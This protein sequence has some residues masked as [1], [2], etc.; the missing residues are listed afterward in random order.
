MTRVR[1]KC[2][3]TLRRLD[4]IEV[5]EHIWVTR[6]EPGASREAEALARLGHQVWCQPVLEIAPL[7]LAETPAHAPD[8]VITVSGH[9]A[10][11]ALAAGLVPRTAAALHIAIG[12]ET[13]RV[14]AQA[15]IAARVP[16][17]ATSEGVLAMPE[18]RNLPPG[19][20]V[21]LWAGRGGRDVLRQA[22]TATLGCVVVKFELYLRRRCAPVDLP[23]QPITAVIVS[24]IEGLQAFTDTWQQA[25]GGYNVCL[26]V[27]SP[28]VAA[29]AR[30]LGFA[31]LVESDGAD[32]DAVCAAIAKLDDC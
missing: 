24:S 32:V 25:G 1:R 15:D 22:L 30:T 3:T 23:E 20:V 12:A 31:H 9:A 17:A 5:G 29:E 27:V 21:W 16:Q 19:S 18:I 14:L 11:Q 8:V 2:S 4:T 26:V 10:R 6:T 28:R 13:A 7:P